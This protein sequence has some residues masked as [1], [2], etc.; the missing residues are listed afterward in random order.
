MSHTISYPDDLYEKVVEYALRHGTTPEEALVALTRK[1]LQTEEAGSEE[2]AIPDNAPFFQLAGC[3]AS[4]TP[5]LGQHHGPI[6]R[7]GVFRNT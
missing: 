5:D 4:G 7:R 3:L 2:V 1:A 6:S